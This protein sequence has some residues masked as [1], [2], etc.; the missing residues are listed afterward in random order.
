MELY[1]KCEVVQHGEVPIDFGVRYVYI[2]AYSLL[3]V[4]SVAGES[5]LSSKVI[6]NYLVHLG[7]LYMYKFPFVFVFMVLILL[8]LLG[9]T[10]LVFLKSEDY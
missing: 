8:V 5:K 4:S 9:G 6:Y 2:Y 10:F 1:V 3:D 7:E